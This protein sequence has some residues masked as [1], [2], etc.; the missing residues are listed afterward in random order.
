MADGLH[1]SPQTDTRKPHS[2]WV[3][4]RRHAEVDEVRESTEPP[5]A[6]DIGH[7]HDSPASSQY[8][9]ES[10]GFGDSSVDFI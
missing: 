3:S 6:T 10:L 7:P 4:T 8:D 5:M 9:G 1:T 2:D